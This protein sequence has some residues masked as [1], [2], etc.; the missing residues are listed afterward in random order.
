MIIKAVLRRGPFSS[1]IKVQDGMEYIHQII[2]DDIS[3][4]PMKRGDER[5]ILRQTEVW[6]FRFNQ[7]LSEDIAEYVFEGVEKR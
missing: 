1:W 6:R 7:Y 2:P 3:F 4:K 5:P